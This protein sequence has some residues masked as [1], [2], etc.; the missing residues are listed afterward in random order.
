MGVQHEG[1]WARA[2]IQGL[3]DTLTSSSLL[4]CGPR[5][6]R[7]VGLIRGTQK[8]AGR[9]NLVRGTLAT[10]VGAGSCPG[11]TQPLASSGA[12]SPLGLLDFL[13]EKEG[14][15]LDPKSA[16][17]SPFRHR[18]LTLAPGRAHLRECLLQAPVGLVQV[19]VDNDQVKQTGF[20]A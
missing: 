9:A 12:A 8:E 14:L 5:S 13:P 6:H 18:D 3:K 15:T 16:V 1:F 17:P 20:L 19:V 4:G 10:R 7:R 11:R 2:A